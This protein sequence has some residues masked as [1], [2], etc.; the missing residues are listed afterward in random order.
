[1]SNKPDCETFSEANFQVE[2]KDSKLPVL[3]VFEADWSGTCH[4]MTPILEDLC[5][6]FKGRVKI[7]MVDIETNVRLVE[8]YG[9]LN[10][11]SLIFF[12][13]GEIVGHIT[14]SAPKHIIAARLNDLALS[15]SK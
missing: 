13:N 14:G 12:N 5:G 6:E 8:D 1:M 2:V 4:I 7:G 3:V 10:I 11:P 15:G 9:I